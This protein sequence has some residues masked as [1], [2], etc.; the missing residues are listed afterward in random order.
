VGTGVDGG[1]RV[2]FITGAASGIGLGMATAFV[3]A[4]M[5]VVV[6]DLSADH[7]DRAR[8]RLAGH[9]CLFLQLDVTDRSGWELAADEAERAY[10]RV[11]ILC[12]NAGF[13]LMGR[14]AEASYDDWDWALGVNLGGAVNG[15]QTFLGR[16]AG[17]GEGGHIVSTASMAALTPIN[18]SG[19]YSVAKRGVVALM[20]SLRAELL[21][22]GI[23]VSVLCPGLTRTNTWGSTLQR[24]TRYAHSGYPSG[25]LGPGELR[26]GHG[27]NVVDEVGMD[28]V[29]LGRRVLA[30]IRRNDLYILTHAELREEIAMS[31]APLVAAFDTAPEPARPPGPGGGPPGLGLIYT[32]EGRTGTRVAGGA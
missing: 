6:T 10:G 25:G 23:G 14:I 30:G 8:E 1:G 11:H 17:H 13:G 16:I 7:L 5:K 22:T 24:P 12:N 2:A 20:E 4:G 3:E 32:P 21:G 18:F 29:E 27:P 15:V 28:P 31:F 26:E 9:D 19:I